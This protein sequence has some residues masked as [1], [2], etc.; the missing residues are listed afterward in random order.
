MRTVGRNVLG[1]GLIVLVGLVAGCR[2][3]SRAGLKSTASSPPGAAGIGSA[4]SSRADYAEQRQQFRTKLLRRGPSPQPGE[5]LETPFGAQ[6]ITYRSGDLTLTAFVDPPPADG[7]KRPAVLFLHGGFAFGA[8]DW[9]MPQP[10]RAAG[11]V[12]MVPVLRGENGQPGAFSAFYDEVDDVVGAAEALA[13]LP[14]VDP[15]RIFLSGHS[16]GGTLALLATMTSKRFRAATS[17]SGSPDLMN[18]VREQP[19]LVVFDASNPRELELRSAVVYAGSF[20]CPVRMYYGSMEFWAADPS[21]RTAAL[22]RQRGL[23]VEAVMVPGDHFSSVPPAIAK[24]IEFF[25]KHGSM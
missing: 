3:S 17:L 11:Y 4:G 21:A 20:Q 16:A 18:V 12:V 5:P 22:A 24:S 23:D 15:A 10:F 9:E 7:R 19:E 6:R 14:Y 25:G 1:P 2:D 8:E 13:G